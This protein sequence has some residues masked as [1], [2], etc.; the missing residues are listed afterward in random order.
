[1]ILGCVSGSWGLDHI[2]ART[3]EGRELD[4]SQTSTTGRDVAFA[5]DF[6]G[7]I[8]ALKITFGL[9]SFAEGGPFC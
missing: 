1:M 4:Q 5:M 2:P 7:S 8:L 3:D 6:N 9:K